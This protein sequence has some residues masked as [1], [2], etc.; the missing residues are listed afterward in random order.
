MKKNVA[1][2]IVGVEMITASDG[3]AFTGAVTVYV[4]GDGGT[5]AVGSVGSGACTHEGNGFHTYAPAQAETNYDHV[6]FTFTGSGAIPVTIQIY[7]TFPQ[8][9]DSYT[10]LGSPVGASVS[11]DIAVVDGNV[12]LILVD[13]GTTLETHLT[14]I[15]GGTFSGSTDSLEAIRNRGD[16]A[17]ITGGTPPTVAAIRAEIDS[18]STQLAAIVAD[19]SELQ[20]DWVNGG[21]LDLL[22]DGVKAVTD[23]L[24][25]S[26]TLSS[27]ATASALTTVD[28]VV[29]AI[30]AKT[31]SLTFTDAGKVDATLQAAADIK[32]AV[33]NKVADHTLRRSSTNA[34][35]SSDGDTKTLRSLAGAVAKQ[36]NKIAISGS[37]LTVYEADDS[38]SLGTQTVTTSASADPVT[39]LDTN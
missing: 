26:G 11:A 4:T 2:Q 35:A 1:S 22:L 27:I 24:P 37:T 19:T 21:R 5:Q 13:T 25:N 30:K 32:A 36:V 17:W 14:D 3:S 33:A 16:A 8:T 23:N 39:G 9:G 6:A 34:L 38:T 12:D 18:N 31:D 7:T 20:T 28:T 10:R 15:K 29:D